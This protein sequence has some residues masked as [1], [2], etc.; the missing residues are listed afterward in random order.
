MQGPQGKVIRG[1]L[2]TSC[3]LWPHEGSLTMG[4]PAGPEIWCWMQLVLEGT[5]L[6]GGLRA[7]AEAEVA[8]AEGELE[9]L[10]AVEQAPTSI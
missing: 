10:A 3:V 4:I 7:V 8:G 6:R 5:G 2:C 1:A 9:W